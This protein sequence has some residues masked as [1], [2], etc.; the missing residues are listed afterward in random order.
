MTKSFLPIFLLTFLFSCKSPDPTKVENA[1]NQDSTNKDTPLK[2]P[3]TLSLKKL[4]FYTLQG[5]SVVVPSFEIEISLSPK[6]KER[7]VNSNETIIIAIFLEGTPKDPSKAHFEE[8][9]SFFVGTAKRE[10]TYGQI[11]MFDNLK[12]PKKIY[13]QL[14]DKNADLTV[15]IYTGRKSSQD[16]LIT[17]DFLSDKVSNIINKRF[18][19]KQKLIYG[20][21]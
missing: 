16:N 6:A 18:T 8:D 20:D 9:G 11:A 3:D 4:G 21:D 19:L 7:I 17:G 10:I 12:F 1:S 14:A 5:D 2:K 13:D 15:N